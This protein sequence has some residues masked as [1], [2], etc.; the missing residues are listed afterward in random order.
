MSNDTKNKEAEIHC[1]NMLDAF[2][3]G[4]E[5]EKFKPTMNSYLFDILRLIENL[6]KRVKELEDKIR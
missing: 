2:R 4:I 1:K 3:S 5:E 6:Q